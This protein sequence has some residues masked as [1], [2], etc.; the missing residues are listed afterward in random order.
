MVYVL[1]E[2]QVKKTRE[3]LAELERNF[4]R[5]IQQPQPSQATAP[6][7]LEGIELLCCPRIF[8]IFFVFS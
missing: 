7:G 3:E 1:D 5:R 6:S 4:L 8:L 2:A